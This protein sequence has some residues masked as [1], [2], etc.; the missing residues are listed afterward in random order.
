MV[1]LSVCLLVA[2]HFTWDNFFFLPRPFRHV[3]L[4]TTNWQGKI[5]DTL[6]RF[7]CISPSTFSLRAILAMGKT[8]WDVISGLLQSLSLKAPSFLPLCVIDD[9][10]SAS[11]YSSLRTEK[12]KKKKKNQ[13]IE[14]GSSILCKWHTNKFFIERKSRNRVSMREPIH[15]L[16]LYSIKDLVRK[17]I[18]HSRNL[19]K[20]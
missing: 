1:C 14:K 13:Q 6:C 2:V 8:H 15:L 7:S 12:K 10:L 16:S 20:D 17:T 19:N 9:I 3:Y 18:L 5:L 4:A 11:R